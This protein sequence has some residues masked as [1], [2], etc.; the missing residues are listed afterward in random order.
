MMQG[1]KCVWMDIP[2]SLVTTLGETELPENWKAIPAPTGTRDIGDRWYDARETPA[3]KV[4][5]TIIPTEFNFVLNPSHH[6][7]NKVKIGEIQDFGFDK[8][9]FPDGNEK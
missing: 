7:F 6:D 1:F 4:P 8:R 3:L 2:K 9:L 5:S